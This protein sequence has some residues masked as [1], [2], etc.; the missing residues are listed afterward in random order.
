[1]EFPK[2]ALARFVYGSGY[3]DE[4]IVVRQRMS[5]GVLPPLLV[6]PVERIL[7]H[8]ELVDFG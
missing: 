7:R 2:R 1:M 6:L 4:T 3:F 5:N 8:D